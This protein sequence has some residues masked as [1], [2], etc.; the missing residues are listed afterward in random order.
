MILLELLFKVR[1]GYK[2]SS[3]SSTDVEVKVVRDPGEVAG[4]AGRAGQGAAS[5]RPELQ[6]LKESYGEEE[7]LVPGQQL[8][9]AVAA[10]DTE[11][12]H[13][14]VLHKPSI[15]SEETLWPELVRLREILGI[16]HDEGDVHTNRGPGR[17]GE[18][19]H[20]HLAGGEV[21]DGAGRHA[22][23]PLPLCDHCLCVGQ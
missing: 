11:R 5:R 23:H 21:R 6:S 16:V 22:R 12:D 18:L 14:L 2:T 17:N 15:L 20:F 8:P 19:P 9:H 3:T 10:A 13:P 7:H 1:F 4:V